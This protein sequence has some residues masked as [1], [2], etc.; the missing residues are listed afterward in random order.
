[1][2]FPMRYISAS[3]TFEDY[4]QNLVE[5]KTWKLLMTIYDGQSTWLKLFN[6]KPVITVINNK[7]MIECREGNSNIYQMINAF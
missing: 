5:R 6:N 3:K 4:G 2:I 1:M 7:P